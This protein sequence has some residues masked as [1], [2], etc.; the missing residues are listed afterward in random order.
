MN[1]RA[2]PNSDTGREINEV[3]GERDEMNTWGCSV[4]M[5]GEG[6]KVNR[7]SRDRDLAMVAGILCGRWAGK[8]QKGTIR[9]QKEGWDLEDRGDGELKR[10]GEGKH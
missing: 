9:E 8:I 6:E 2:D 4:A 10:K 5:A 7:V 1:G 3:R